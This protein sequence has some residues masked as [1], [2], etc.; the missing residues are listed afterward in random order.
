MSE[1]VVTLPPPSPAVARI[2]EQGESLPLLDLS[3]FIAGKPGADLQLAADIRLIQETLGFYAI[4]NYGFDPAIIARTFEQNYKLFALPEEARLPFRYQDHM[5]GYW[6]MRPIVAVRPGY[7]GEAEKGSMLG[8]WA[9]LRERAPDDPKVLAGM[10]HRAMNKWPDPELLPDYRP[11]V[12]QYLAEMVSLGLK[13]VEV[14]ALSLDLPRDYFANH[15]DELEWYSRT[16]F[17]K[18]TADTAIT[19]HSDHSFLTLLPV[20]PVQGLQVRTPTGSWIDAP[21]TQGTLVVN[22]GEWL[23]QLTN[24]RYIATPHRVTAPKADRISIPV[25]VNPN[26]DA[27]NDPVPGS[28][29]EGEERRYPRRDWHSFF[30]SYIDGYTTAVASQ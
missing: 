23:N 11:V 10:R 30:L 17:M 29:K 1:Q 20:S 26:D 12:E 21:K 6:P 14:Y 8:G 25:F 3:D 19:P 18:K 24:G 27:M 7:E 9:F 28:V 22:T 5:Q 16:N 2:I 13:L 15:F 4:V